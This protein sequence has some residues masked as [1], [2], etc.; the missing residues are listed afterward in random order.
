[1]NR[2]R[3]RRAYYTL[4]GPVVFVIYKVEW[5]YTILFNIWLMEIDWC[6]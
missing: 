6:L 2:G 1:M 5:R 4:S 3:L